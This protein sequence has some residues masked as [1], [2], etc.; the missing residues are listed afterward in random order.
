MFVTYYRGMNQSFTSRHD[1]SEHKDTSLKPA[2]NGIGWAQFLQVG[3]RV[4]VRYQIDRAASGGLGHTDALGYIAEVSPET[5]TV[6]TKRGADT[7]QRAKIVAAKPVPPPP[8]RRVP[9]QS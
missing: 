8:A 4:S 6:M 1:S 2:E 7:V 5:I 9:K 3:V